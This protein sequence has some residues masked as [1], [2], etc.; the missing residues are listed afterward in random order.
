MCTK[1]ITH[2]HWYIG[3]NLNT[4]REEIRLLAELAPL[5]VN[6]TGWVTI[7]LVQLAVGKNLSR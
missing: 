1:S 5:S 2:A 4:K 7:S 3:Q 6:E